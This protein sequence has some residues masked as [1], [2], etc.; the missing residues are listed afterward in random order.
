[1]I[2]T[3]V[4]GYGLGGMAFHAPLIDAVPELELAA[5]A[6]SRLDAVRERYADVAVTDAESLIAD[7]SIALVAI[8]TPN[9]SHFPLARAAL[10]AGKH[11]VIDKPFAN[12][13]EDGEALIAL[14]AERGL[15]LS[16]FHNRRWDADLLTVAKLLESGRLGDVRLAEFRW[17]RY[18]PEVSTLWRDKPGVGSGMLADLGPHLIDQALLLFGMP[19]ALT[20]DVAVQ[21]DGA[22]TDDYFDITL[23]YG[24]RR[25]IL[26][27]SRLIAGAR[28]RF[29]LHGT[30][31]SFVKRGLDPQEPAMK[32]G[33]NPNAPDYGVEDPANHGVLTF[34][35]GSTETLPSERGDYRRFYAGV[36]QA[37]ANGT[38]APVT[39]QD[40]VAGLR[41]MAFARQSSDEGRRI[42]L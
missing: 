5:I 18:R 32:V 1:M 16:A 8:S 20:A 15:V 37:I 12:S 14:A 17:D 21:R 41:I 33:G 39:A 24:V 34:G 22:V 27:A 23:H 10:E 4:I 2:R 9:D 35:D 28:P 3:G 26:S 11:V 31:G 38:P 42:S 25:V 13:V 40:A 19:E 29:A 30:L 7:P 36:G 6:T